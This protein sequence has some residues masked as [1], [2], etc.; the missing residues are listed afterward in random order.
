M[1]LF[2][3]IWRNFWWLILFY[4]LFIAGYEAWMTWD[5]WMKPAG[6]ASRPEI[7][8]IAPGMTFFE[9]ARLLEY[10]RLIR[11]SLGFSILAWVR[12]AQGRL[13]AGEYQFSPTQRP[14]EMLDYIVSGRVLEHIVTIPEGFNIYDIAG[15]VE[16]AGL[17]PKERFLKA[18]E[19][20][21]LL[22][23]LGIDGDSVEGY[24]FP[25]TYFFTKAASPQKII[26]TM[27]G[28]L[29]QVW[30]KEGF[31][32]RAKAMGLS[33]K[34]VLTLA[35]MVEKEAVLPEERPIIA[36]VFWNRI[37]KGM[38]LQSDPT[39]SYGMIDPYGGTK[40]KL[41]KKE[42]ETKTPYN[43]Y[44]IKGLPKGP[45]ANPGSD[46]IRAVLYPE[47]TDFL[48]F[49][50][51]N[52]GTHYFSRTLAEHNRAVDIYQ[53]GQGVKETAGKGGDTVKTGR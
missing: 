9:V 19:D 32:E 43:T 3:K 51:K 47:K 29:D 12:N 11:S 4:G 35:S 1:G 17:M 39:V 23:K 25:D 20:K 36:G 10:K 5:E 15:L 41:T 44:C 50:S 22:N 31:Y 45:I 7:I 42:L 28:R 26:E 49:V 27:V 52:N 37:K 38:P 33:M 6:T 16:M 53:R 24:L 2:R 14:E 30:K 46:S 48:Y 8:N 40:P 13:Q 34:E 18:A 21:A